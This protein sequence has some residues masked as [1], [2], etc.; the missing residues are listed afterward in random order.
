MASSK[1]STKTGFSGFGSNVVKSNA[2]AKKTTTTPTNFFSGGVTTS[3]PKSAVATGSVASSFKSGA[4]NLT[5][6]GSGGAQ[7][8]AAKL[9][10]APVSSFSSGTTILANTPVIDQRIGVNSLNSQSSGSAIT[11][12]SSP[13][14]AASAPSIGTYGTAIQGSVATGAN[15]TTGLYDTATTDSVG[16]PK[17]TATTGTEAPKLSAGEQFLKDNNIPTLEKPKSITDEYYKSDAF[18]AQ[19]RAQRQMN[20]TQNAIN[21]ITTRL[22]TDLANLR[23]VGANEGVTEAVYGQQ[24]SQ[25]IREGNNLLLPLQAQLAADQGNLELATSTLNT[26]ATMRQKDLENEYSYKKSLRDELV[27]FAT[28]DQKARLDAANR[29]S[30]RAFELQKLAIQNDYATKLRLLDKATEN[31]GMQEKAQMQ[32]NEALSLAKELRQDNAI[33]K[34]S[35]VGASLAKFVPYGQALGLQGERTAFENKVNTLKSN[36]T[37]DN[38]KLLKGA[39]SDKDLLFLNSIG[40][41]LSTDMSE[42]TFNQE[43]DKIASKLEKAGASTGSTNNTVTAPNGEQI[44]IID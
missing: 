21:A 37:L 4:S 1:G 8:A 28:D 43:L 3:A 10:Q 24:S 29:A 41:S 27:K 36:L 23:G 2:A 32:Q 17:V 31:V 6:K 12:G 13:V 20:D 39:M 22:N 9:A 15:P 18:K 40:S 35:A 30:D 38:L 34:K 42:K 7:S 16:N 14:L 19:Q 26:W 44:I 25:I 5:N 33:G 11:A